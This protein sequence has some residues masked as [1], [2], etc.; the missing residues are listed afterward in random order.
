MKVT[1]TRTNAVGTTYFD[2]DEQA[3]TSD[4]N[5]YPV[6]LLSFL[7]EPKPITES[8]L[9]YLRTLLASRFQ[10][11]LALVYLAERLKT[12]DDVETQAML[13]Q[14]DDFV[15]QHYTE[16]L[17]AER[18]TNWSLR[19][20]KRQASLMFWVFRNKVL[21]VDGWEAASR[22]EVVTRV[23]HKVLSEE[24]AFEKLKADIERFRKMGQVSSAPREPIPE[25][26][27][28][29]VWRRDQGRCVMCG[30]QERIEFDHIIPLEKGGNNT[31]RNIQI[32]CETC[33]RK[34]GVSI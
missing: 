24:K 33:N 11:K 22:E 26:V 25:D 1:V 3:Q 14:G 28:I 12:K 7:A 10:N 21:K 18:W 8:D 29:F 13:Q 6:R 17:E 23:T 2:A 20:E 15:V 19:D 5:R 34:K 27:R 32:L 9:E 4:T 31:T 16:L 30:S